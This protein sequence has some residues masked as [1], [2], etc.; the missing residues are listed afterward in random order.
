MNYKDKFR[1][2]DTEAFNASIARDILERMDKLRLGANNN[3]KR[4]WV[5]ELIQNAKDAAQRDLP[6]E[7]KINLSD[8]K[9]IFSHNGKC[10][11]ANDITF[12]IRQVSN[13]DREASEQEFDHKPTGKFGTG[14]LTTHLL[15][16]Q[17]EIIG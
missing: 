11:T 3:L 10:F 1:Q 16:E 15:S 5:W 4:R 9:L 8:D 14:F 13:K 6:V 7:I 2:A 17:V 12:L